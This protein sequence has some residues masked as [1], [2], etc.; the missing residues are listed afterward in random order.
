MLPSRTRRDRDRRRPYR[1][2]DAGTTHVLEAVIVVSVMLSATV[3]VVTYDQPASGA[4]VA[5]DA[6]E[7]RARDALK[8]LYDTP[9]DS[10]FGDDALS[11]YVAQCLNDDCDALASRLDK[12]VPPGASYALYVSNGYATYPVIV[13]GEPR[14]EAVT[15]T[16]AFEP[17]WSSTFVATATDAVGPADPLLVYALPIFHSTVLSPG[18]SQLLVK[19]TGS[20]ADGSDY[21]LTA[22]Y[23]TIAQDAADPEA[24]A[25]SLVF[26][27]DDGAPLPVVNLSGGAGATARLRLQLAQTEEGGQVPAG[28]EVALHVPRGWTAIAPPAENAAWEIVQDAE[29]ANGTRDGSTLRAVLVDPL[30]V[31]A[32]TLELDVTY[33]GDVLDYYPFVATLSKGANGIASVLVRGEERGFDPPAATPTVHLS[34]PG[35]MGAGAETTWTVAAYIPVSDAGALPDEVSDVVRVRTVE[36]TEQEDNPI[37]DEDSL[38]PIEAMG[39]EWRASPT[40]LVWEGD[41]AMHTSSLLNLSFKLRASGVPGPQESR[42]HFLPPVAFDDYTGR[43][44]ERSGWGFYRQ[45]VLPADE[46]YA[47]FDPTVTDAT[48]PHPLVSEGVYRAT[49]LPGA[50]TYDVSGLAAIQ[51]TLYG[52]YVS[53]ERRSVA[54]GGEVVIS[55]NVQSLLF[56]LAEAGQKAGVTLRFY[57]PWSGDARE[58]I[59]EQTNLDQGFL[60]GEVSQMIVMDI[61]GDGYGDPVIGTTN[62]RVIAYHGLTGQR[63]QGDAYAVPVTPAAQQQKA[64]ARITALAPITL[65][66]EEYIV[67]ATDKN[68]DGVFVLTKDFQLAWYYAFNSADTLAVDTSTDIDLDG[69]RDIVVA[70]AYEVGVSKN[71]LVYVFRAYEGQELLVPLTPTPPVVEDANAF[72]YSLGTPS[73]VLGQDEFGPDGEGPGVLV[74]IQTLFEPGLRVDRSVLPPHVEQGSA[75]T[76]R[77]GV[78]GIAADGSPTST[79]FGAPANVLRTYDRDADGVDDVALGGAS[80][81]VILA[82]GEALTQPIYSYLITGAASIVSADARSG[83]ESYVLTQEGQVIWTDDAWVSMYGP[84]APAAGARAISANDHN[85]YWVVGE[86]GAAWKSAPPAAPEPDDP[87]M[88]RHPASRE[89]EPVAL[90]PTRAGQPYALTSLHELRDVWFRGDD[91]W[92]VGDVCP[93]V[94]EE[95]ILLRTQD[96][97]ATWVVLSS[98]DGTLVGLDG[99]V[100]RSL[101][102]IEFASDGVGWIV[103]EQGMILRRDPAGEPWTQQELATTYD[104]LDIAC[105]PGAPSECLAVGES[106]AA[107]E[108]TDGATWTNVTGL[109]GLGEEKDLYTVGF[110]SDDR[111]YLGSENAVL[112]RFGDADWTELPLNYVP[113]DG[114]A[115]AT[116]GDGTGFAYGGSE[117]N[118]RIWLLHDYDIRSRAQTTDLLAGLPGCTALTGLGITDGNVTLAQQVIRVEASTDGTAWSSLGEVAENSGADA[119]IRQPRPTFLDLPSGAPCELYLRITFE[120]AGDKTILSPFVR[121]LELTVNYTDGGPLQEIVT[122]DFETD[123]FKDAARTTAAWDTSVGALHQP[124]V[125]EFWTRDVDGEVHDLQT[126]YDV[127]GDGLHEVWVGTGDILSENSPDYIIYGDLDTVVAPDDR[128]RVLDGET[129]HPLA[130]SAQLQGEVRFLRIADPD[131]DGEPDEVYAATWDSRAADG[132]G[133]L[134]KLH[135]VT[136]Q[137]LWQTE[138]GREIPGDMEV[139]RLLDGDAAVFLGT[140]R[141]AEQVTGIGHVWAFDGEEEERAWRIVSDDMGKYLITKEVE[142]G[143]LFGPY[144]VEVEVEW[145]QTVTESCE[146]GQDLIH[147]ARFYDHFMVTPPDLVSPPTPVYTARLLVWMDDW[148]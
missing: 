108:T 31:G 43:L 26:V 57:P 103:G 101:T 50:T 106:G 17:R 100:G 118:G 73:T 41:V 67:V 126:G 54:V 20:R 76:P 64:V 88:R 107:F 85:S 139:D 121:E 148:S 141:A 84:T 87:T 133:V 122:L 125:E 89:L 114:R 90:A 59:F 69:E 94:C 46:S 120:T 112:A 22:A 4:G 78:Q 32:Q 34:V 143:W 42:T 53:A 113:N 137:I 8:I 19:V 39:G 72:S 111:A 127:T 144:V 146:V 51:D 79:L 95:P 74:P 35:P 49:E 55:A 115:I 11:A 124:L 132:I 77:A 96:R 44:V 86:G 83:A 97:G 71:A 138:F 119:D 2:E 63:L 140:Q 1:R 66:G 24:T 12:L 40:S 98:A 123:A 14:G 37:F 109:R 102:S 58:P 7:L 68:S 116:A 65:Y 136:L 18:G 91:G 80:G 30:L 13:D 134:Y 48:D 10:K 117:G 15:A 61:N 62:G 45:A 128:V 25:T 135:P 75:S 60:S 28:A 99:P 6:L 3:F 29:D 142:P 81:Y 21:V 145:C 130:V 38:Q 110:V 56:A 5:T 27:D 131:G 147:S 16:Q 9:V 129:G 104:L 82:N 47:G 105:K 23:S 33:H 70:R 92:I 36:I 93:L 52:S